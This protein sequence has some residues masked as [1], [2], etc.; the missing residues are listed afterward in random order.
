MNQLMDAADLV[1]YELGHKRLAG[2]F[3]D[4][5]FEPSSF[6]SLEAAAAADGAAAD[7]LCMC[8]QRS[9]KRKAKR[10]QARRN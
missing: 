9:S 5:H 2:S 8:V 4:P 1:W 3:G 10:E 7:I 6:A